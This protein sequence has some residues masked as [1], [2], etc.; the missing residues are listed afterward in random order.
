M[1]Q[2]RYFISIFITAYQQL[3]DNRIGMTSKEV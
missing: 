3:Q 1:D 2:F